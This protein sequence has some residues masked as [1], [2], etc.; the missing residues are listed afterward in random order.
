MIL[1]CSSTEFGGV[2]K[3]SNNHGGRSNTP[4]PVIAKVETSTI[5]GTIHMAYKSLIAAMN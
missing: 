5:E 4:F 1:L 3:G 2:V